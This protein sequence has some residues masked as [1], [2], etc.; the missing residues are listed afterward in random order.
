M[1]IDR[2]ENTRQW[3]EAG[4]MGAMAQHLVELAGAVRGL[5][6]LDLACGVGTCAMA[7][8]AAEA[9]V[10]AIDK[11]EAMVAECRENALASE[12]LYRASTCL[13]LPGRSHWVNPSVADARHLELGES[14]FDIV[15]GNGAISNIDAP[16][17]ALSEAWRVLKPNGRLILGDFLVPATVIDLWASVRSFSYGYRRP[18]LH[19]AQLQDLLYEAKFQIE[20]FRPIRWRYDLHGYET[21]K[22]RHADV[23]ERCLNTLRTLPATAQRALRYD[24]ETGIMDYECFALVATKF[25]DEPKWLILDLPPKPKDADQDQSNR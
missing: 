20:S 25:S 15:T 18:Y 5:Q 22:R 16:A 11:D 14:C 7:F 10:S 1:E 12:L 24:P 2:R 3:R 21:R 13:P 4:I 19:Y 23:T 6:V 8:A 9:Q 17:T